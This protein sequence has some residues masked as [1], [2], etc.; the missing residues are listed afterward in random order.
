MGELKNTHD[1][2]ERSRHGGLKSRFERKRVAL[3]KGKSMMTVLEKGKAQPLSTHSK[4]AAFPL[5]P[6]KKGAVY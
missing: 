2:K 5:K 4:G 6:G 3:S 1:G